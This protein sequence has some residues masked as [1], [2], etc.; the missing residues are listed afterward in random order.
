MKFFATLMIAMS[1]VLAGC[2][3][4]K[5]A[6]KVA[7]PTTVVQCPKGSTS[8]NGFNASTLV[9]K[10]FKEAQG[11]ASKYDCTVRPVEVD[12]EPKAVTMDYSESRINVILKDDVITKVQGIG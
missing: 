6:P 12:G 11:T 3:D 7:V 5:P 9:G 10:T 1:L 4:N 8:S 2:G